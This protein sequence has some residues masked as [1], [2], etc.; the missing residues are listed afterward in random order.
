MLKFNGTEDSLPKNFDNDEK[1]L[2]LEIA[3]DMLHQLLLANRNLT[4]N[5]NPTNLDKLDQ[6]QT[7]FPYHPC[8]EAVEKYWA[9]LKSTYIA[10]MDVLWTMEQLQHSQC[11]SSGT[12]NKTHV[13]SSQPKIESIETSKKSFKIQPDEDEQSLS[14][15]FSSTRQDDDSS[16][17]SSSITSSTSEVTAKASTASKLVPSEHKAAKDALLSTQQQLDQT[18]QVSNDSPQSGQHSDFS[19]APTPNSSSPSSNHPVALSPPQ[20]DVACSPP[21]PPNSIHKPEIPLK[22]ARL[23][24]NSNKS[25]KQPSKVPPP[26]PKPPVFHQKIMVINNIS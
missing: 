14:A 26:R 19:L 2:N 5:Q 24:T 21:I 13:A 12:E 16:Q 8:L 3:F 10:V 9:E 11:T 17:K 7:N 23:N 6:T 15:A 18:R 20:K 4:T 1:K 25:S 22:P